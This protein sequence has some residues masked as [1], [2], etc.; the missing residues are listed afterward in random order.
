M[1]VTLLYGDAPAT[2]A[3]ATSEGENL[4]LPLDELRAA[5]GWELK[6]EGACR[7]DVCVPVP[8]ERERDFL[9]GDRRTFNLAVLARLLAQPAVHDDAGQVWAFGE[10]A[11]TKRAAM[12]GLE[13]PDFVLPDR[14]GIIHRLS[15]YRGKKVLLVSW[16]SW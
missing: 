13:A 16:A 5:T 6:P 15:D 10:A 9:R 7:D 12:D 8:A 2:A 4:W 1:A 3:G 11:A 14:D